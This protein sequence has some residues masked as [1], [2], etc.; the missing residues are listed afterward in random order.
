[1]QVIETK[2]GDTLPEWVFKVRRKNPTT[3]KWEDDDLSDVTAVTCY[4]RNISTGALKVNAAAGAVY[5][6]ANALISYSPVAADVDTAAR[7]TFW[8]V[9]TRAGGKEMTVPKREHEPMYV[10]ISEN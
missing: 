5:D 10:N 4:T 8:A 1:M 6:V 2:V 9:L 7:Y 3:D